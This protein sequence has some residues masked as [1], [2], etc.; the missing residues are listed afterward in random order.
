[1]GIALNGDETERLLRVRGQSNGG[2]D[3]HQEADQLIARATTSDGQH[4]W[5]YCNMLTPSLLAINS[6]TVYVG[7]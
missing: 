3:V 4:T 5:Q 2:R 1:V 6:T 7:D